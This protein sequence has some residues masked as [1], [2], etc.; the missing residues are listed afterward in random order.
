MKAVVLDKER[1]FF[2][3]S[4]FAGAILQGLFC[5]KVA[6][7]GAVVDEELACTDKRLCWT[8]KEV[9]FCRGLFAGAVLQEL[10]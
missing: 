5:M 3:R 7:D 1:G 6:K 9:F 8:M 2:S 10:F 4:Q